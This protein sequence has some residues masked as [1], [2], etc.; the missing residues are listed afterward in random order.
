MSASALVTKTG[1]AI[2]SLIIFSTLLGI[3]F[4]WQVYGVLPSIAFDL[5]AVGWGLFVVDSALTF[6]RPKIAYYLGLVL[7]ILALATSLPQSTHYSFIQNGVLL[8]SAT[9]VAG[10][11]AQVLIIVLVL[12]HFVH[13]RRTDEWAWPGAKSAA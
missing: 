4:L 7:A 2:Q 9:F 1:R 8:P 10:T 5:L 12:Y 6:V 3:L 11:A 13:A